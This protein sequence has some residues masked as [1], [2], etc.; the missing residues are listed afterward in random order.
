MRELASS[1]EST[2][3]AERDGGTRAQGT[4]AVA[5]VLSLQV[6]AGNAAVARLL[7][8]DVADVDGPATAFDMETDAPPSTSAS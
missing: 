8:R 2:A 7:A 1:P 5:E 4:T 3:A 6:A